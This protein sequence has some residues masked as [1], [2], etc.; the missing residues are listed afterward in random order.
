MDA[1]DRR[2]KLPA[3]VDR[4]ALRVGLG[5]ATVAVFAQAGARVSLL[6]VDYPVEPTGLPPFAGWS[7][8]AVVNWFADRIAQG[9]L[10]LV[11]GAASSLSASADRDLGPVLAG[12]AA[13][14]VVYAA[15]VAGSFYVGVLVSPLPLDLGQ[16]GRMF[17]WQFLAF[18]AASGVG[19]LAG[20]EVRPL[21]RSP[22]GD[23]ADPPRW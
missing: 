3:A 11:L 21:L 19:T 18:G 5:L 8:D 16:A 2:S 20:N 22:D 17:A 9:V 4:S 6:V 15:G 1:A 7:W 23:D 14:A 10:L 12:F 13:G